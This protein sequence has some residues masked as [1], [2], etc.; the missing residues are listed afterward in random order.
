[1][2][3]NPDTDQ[4]NNDT[5]ASEDTDTDTGEEEEKTYTDR[6]LDDWGDDDKPVEVRAISDTKTK[7][8][9]ESVHDNQIM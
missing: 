7:A 1:M 5:E 2:L 6:D 8:R 3:T 9:V 4:A